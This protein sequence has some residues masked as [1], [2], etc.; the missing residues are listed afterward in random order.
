MEDNKNQNNKISPPAKPNIRPN[1][2][3]GVNFT[4]TIQT[5][6]MT[7]LEQS[8]DK[9]N[10]TIVKQEKINKKTTKPLS[11]KI[12]II[13]SV[14]A[15]VVALSLLTGLIYL[16]FIKPYTPMD[17]SINFSANMDFISDGTSGEE[18][19][20]KAMPGDDFDLSYV[21]KS[22]SIEGEESYAV[23][24]RITS[25]A[26]CENNYYG[27][28]F[29]ISFVDNNWYVGNDGYYYYK[30]VLQPD[31]TIDSVKAIHINEWVGNEFASKTV[32]VCLVAEALQAGNGSAESIWPTAPQEWLNIVKN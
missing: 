30:G 27:N 6:P 1:L 19:P 8:S 13:T 4:N 16:A 15:I 7:K 21:I 29:S 3:N 11:T 26:I 10:T 20:R 31:T 9:K 28:I 14:V 5:K 18:T 24:V 17:I 12:K 23:Y 22:E 2:P 25:Y 32:S